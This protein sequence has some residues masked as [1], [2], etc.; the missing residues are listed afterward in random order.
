MVEG[1]LLQ[2]KAFEQQA[3]AEPADE[4]DGSAAQ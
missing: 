3:I 2:V 1:L 4:A